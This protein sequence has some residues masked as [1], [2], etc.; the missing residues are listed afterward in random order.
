MSMVPNGFAAAFRRFFPDLVGRPV[1]VALSGGADS[2]ALL[3]IL[4]EVAG[5]LG[6]EVAAAHVHHH[7]RG[8]EADADA[9]TARSCAVGSA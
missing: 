3:C 2:V 7:L 9:A 4:R 8:D 5:E 1:L 6:C